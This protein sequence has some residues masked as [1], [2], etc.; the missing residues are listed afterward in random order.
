[1]S[2]AMSDD[3][4]VE[5]LALLLMSVLITLFMYVHIYVCVYVV[6]GAER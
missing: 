4:A 1:M 5:S 2:T 6:K 3:A